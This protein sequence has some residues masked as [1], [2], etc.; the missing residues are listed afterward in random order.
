MKAF[1]SGVIAAILI[2]VIA[3]LVLQRL[4]WSSAD[5]YRAEGN[6]RL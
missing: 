2:A 5:V 3:A 4:D 1:L 6:V